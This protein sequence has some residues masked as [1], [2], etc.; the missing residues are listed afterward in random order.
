M[1]ASGM[2]EVVKVAVVGQAGSIDLPPKTQQRKGGTRRARLHFASIILSSSTISLTR[3]NPFNCPLSLYE[4][5]NLQ[6]L[7]IIMDGRL[8]LNL[9]AVSNLI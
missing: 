9:S 3:V 6:S 2:V 7:F 4:S 5:F 8:L 1:A